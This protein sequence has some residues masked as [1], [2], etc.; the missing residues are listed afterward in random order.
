MKNLALLTFLKKPVYPGSHPGDIV[1]LVERMLCTH[2]VI[3]PTPIISKQSHKDFQ[4][5]EA[6]GKLGCMRCMQMMAHFICFLIGFALLPL[7][8]I[9]CL[10]Y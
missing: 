2:E 6:L 3:G 10:I 7:P 1:Q 8:I 9:Y 5:A 4:F